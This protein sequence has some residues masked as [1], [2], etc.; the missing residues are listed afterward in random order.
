MKIYKSDLFV[1]TVTVYP[2]NPRDTIK[3]L[4]KLILGKKVGYQ[5]YYSNILMFFYSNNKY[6]EMQMG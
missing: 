2:Q 1:D 4:F 5:I 3:K 6:L